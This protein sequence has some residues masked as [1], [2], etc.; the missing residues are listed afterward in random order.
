MSKN[1]EARPRPGT[2]TGS[3]E[4]SLTMPS[5]PLRLAKDVNDFAFKDL[6]INE[7]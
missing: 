2:Q 5:R 4:F 6:Q 1:S 3:I 7:P